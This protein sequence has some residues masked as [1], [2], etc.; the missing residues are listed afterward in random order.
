MLSQEQLERYRR[1]SPEERLRVS[2]ELTA[3][4]LRVLDGLPSEEGRRRWGIL[5][6][7]HAESSRRLEEAF[8]RLP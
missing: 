8:R 2:L 5:L 3:S 6:D 7:Q 1:M 4:G